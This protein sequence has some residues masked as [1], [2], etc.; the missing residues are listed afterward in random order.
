MKELLPV[1]RVWTISVENRWWYRF[2]S[3][4]I[5]S[6]T[7]FPAELDYKFLLGGKTRISHSGLKKIQIQLF[8]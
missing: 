5:S 7:L 2:T 3:Y 8:L 6:V 4:A 1:S